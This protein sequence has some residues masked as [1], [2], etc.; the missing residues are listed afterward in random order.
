[1]GN[2]DQVTVACYVT[3][4]WWQSNYASCTVG[5][6]VEDVSWSTYASSFLAD[7]VWFGGAIYVGTSGI[8]D[9]AS[10]ASGSW[11]AYA[12]WWVYAVWIDEAISRRVWPPATEGTSRFESPAKWTSA[13]DSSVV[14]WADAF[15]SGGGIYADLGRCALESVTTSYDVGVISVDDALRTSSGGVNANVSSWA[16]DGVASYLSSWNASSIGSVSDEALV[17]FTS[18]VDC[19]V[20][21]FWAW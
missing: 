16:I 2:A 3:A 12:V 9:I 5:G 19:Q 17:A 11:S 8:G 7:G 20:S 14:L 13:V 4:N 1:M 15:W 21:I 18:S 6:R 10:W